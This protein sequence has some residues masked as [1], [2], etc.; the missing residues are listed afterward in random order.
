VVGYEALQKVAF[1][2][3]ISANIGSTSTPL[4][5]GYAGGA[6]GV[7]VTA[8]AYMIMGNLVFR[9]SYHYNAPLHSKLHLSSTKPLIWA[10]AMS[11][12]AIGRNMGYRGGRPGWWGDRRSG[13]VLVRLA[14]PSVD[15]LSGAP[16][17]VEDK[18][19]ERGSI[20][21]GN[22]DSS[23]FEVGELREVVNRP[24][25]RRSLLKGAAAMGAVAALGRL[26]LRGR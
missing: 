1:Y 24:V 3:S 26:G 18:G 11:N 23:W 17:R 10:I 2:N 13:S 19:D 9:G 7:A 8:T 6:E 5:G 12:A 20:V 21:G 16:S 15:L 25:S 22:K 4:F 14:S